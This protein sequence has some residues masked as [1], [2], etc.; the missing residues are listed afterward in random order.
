MMKADPSA[1]TTVDVSD[2][3]LLCFFCPGVWRVIKLDD[4]IELRQ[5]FI[6][7]PFRVVYFRKLELHRYRLFFQP[8]E[9]RVGEP[10]VLASAFREY[11]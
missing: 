4:C 2:E 9:A 5:K 3:S 10:S 6:V 1:Q 8:L 11:E 7:Y